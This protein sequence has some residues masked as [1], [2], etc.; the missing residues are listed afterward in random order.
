MNYQAITN[1]GIQ[2][3]VRFIKVLTAMLLAKFAV[4]YLSVDAQTQDYVM[5]AIGTTIAALLK[6]IEGDKYRPQDAIGFIGSIRDL[7]RIL[8]F[9]TSGK[10]PAAFSSSLKAID[11][12]LELVEKEVEREIT[13]SEKI[14]THKSS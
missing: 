1:R 13:E 6:L 2:S 12:G 8:I 5:I 14:L 10:L 11:T 7:V 4:L 3:F 9:A